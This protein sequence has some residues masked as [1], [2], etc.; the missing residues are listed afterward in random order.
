MAWVI[1]EGLAAGPFLDQQQT[2]AVMQVHEGRSISGVNE[3]RFQIVKKDFF[4]RPGKLL[5]TVF[6]IFQADSAEGWSEKTL[7]FAA[8]QRNIWQT[9][10]LIRHRQPCGPK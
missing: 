1:Y 5:F 9:I 6:Q 4:I 8:S 10:G 2:G 7:S 3:Q